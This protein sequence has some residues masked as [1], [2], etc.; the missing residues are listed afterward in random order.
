MGGMMRKLGGWIR[1]GGFG[2]GGSLWSGS[3]ISY[4]LLLSLGAMTVGCNKVGVGCYINRPASAS[5]DKLATFYGPQAK[6]DCE[7]YRRLHAGPCDTKSQPYI[8]C[9]DLNNRV[10]SQTFCRKD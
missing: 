9:S 7:N 3:V 1:R 6:E 8:V 4:L 2:G 10:Y 5:T